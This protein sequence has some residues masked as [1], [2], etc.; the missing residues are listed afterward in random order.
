MCVVFG[1]NFSPKIRFLGGWVLRKIIY[2]KYRI[3]YILTY[4]LLRRQGEVERPP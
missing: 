3:R 2:Y 4:Y 1:E